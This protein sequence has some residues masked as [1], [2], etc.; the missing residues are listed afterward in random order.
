M[1]FAWEMRGPAD[2]A[3]N[4]PG[5][6]P[7][8]KRAFRRALLRAARN[9]GTWYRNQ[10]I[11]TAELD[12]ETP[13]PGRLHRSRRRRIRLF[14]WNTWALTTE[15]WM[16]LQHYLKEQGFEIVMLQSTCWSFT[17]N[18]TAAGYH[19][20][21][22]GDPMDRHSGI[23]TMISTKLCTPQDLS[24]AEICPGRL[25]HAID[26]FNVYQHPWRSTSS[27]DQNLA[28]RGQIWNSLHESLFRIPFRNQLLLSGDFNA[29]LHNDVHPDHDEFRAIISTHHLG[30]L[31]QDV[32]RQATFFSAQGNSQIDYQFSRRPSVALFTWTAQLGAGE[33]AVITG[34]LW[35][36][37]LLP[38]PG[39]GNL[40]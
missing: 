34:R 23:M 29:T 38:G 28:D 10:W 2:I 35:Q 12:S 25:L 16:E 21:H 24:Y 4:Y 3:G 8:C 5:N 19:V 32:P 13:T 7:P 11:T 18:W 36:A 27:Q 33:V 26:L 17:N 40:E 14:N 1:H 30:S 20:I 37:C 6:R 15:L 22:S 39:V 31:H 9:G